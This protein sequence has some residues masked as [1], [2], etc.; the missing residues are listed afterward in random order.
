MR[1]E[2]RQGWSRQPPPVLT[3]SNHVRYEGYAA[4][5]RLTTDAPVS[6]LSGQ[7][8]VLTRPQRFVL[9]W[10]PPVEEPLTPLCETMLHIREL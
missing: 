8:F 5:L 1:C 10:G 3:G 4:P 7:P 9:A 2:P 6:Y